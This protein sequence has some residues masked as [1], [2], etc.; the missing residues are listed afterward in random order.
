MTSDGVNDTPVLK[1]T[2]VSVVMGLKGTNA[3]REAADMVLADD[4]FATISCAVCE[5]RG[6]YNKSGNS[7]YSCCRPMAEK[8][9]S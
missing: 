2:D 3:A 1:R 9:R 5:G 8:R 6:I 4:N 7:C